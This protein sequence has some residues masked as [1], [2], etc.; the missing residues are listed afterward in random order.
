MG[1][2]PLNSTRPDS[3]NLRKVVTIGTGYY[4]SFAV[5][6]DGDVFAW[7]LN[8]YGQLGLD[9]EASED[10]TVWQP[11]LVP[12]LSPSE[13]GNDARVVQVSGGEHHTLFLLSDGR[14]FACGRFDSSQLGFSP[15]H[16]A[17]IKAQEA[18]LDYV[19]T[20]ARVFFPPVPTTDKPQPD[21][22]KYK[23]AD[24]LKVP[25]PIVKVVASGRYN[26][27]VSKSGHAYSWGYGAES[28]VSS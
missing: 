16:P 24:E 6:S 20:P 8:Q 7:G 11:T 4:H 1:R 10:R 14:V 25:N 21:L 27:A 19:Y 22:P 5:D 23:Q 12:S 28:Q 17:A 18:D 3:L 2:H 13:L 9:P 26:L 15:D